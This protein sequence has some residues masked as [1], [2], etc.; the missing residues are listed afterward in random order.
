M[1]NIVEEILR[2]L[3]KYRRQGTLNNCIA[4]NYPLTQ[5]MQTFTNLNSKLKIY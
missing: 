5:A 3:T 4:A 1:D 2:R